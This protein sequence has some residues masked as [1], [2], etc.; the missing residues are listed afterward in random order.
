MHVERDKGFEEEF[1]VSESQSC[2]CTSAYQKCTATA[3]IELHGALHTYQLYSSILFPGHD[4]RKLL[5][6]QMENMTLP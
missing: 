3:A 1:K 2:V 4:C 5:M 6:I